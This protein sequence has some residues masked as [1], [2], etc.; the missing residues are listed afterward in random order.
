[1]NLVKSICILFLLF[2][3]VDHSK[4]AGTMKKL[5][6][7]STQFAGLWRVDSYD[8]REFATPP[9][10]LE[11]QLSL[12]AQYS[13]FPLGQVMEFVP[14]GAAILPG[15]IDPVSMKASGP[16]GQTMQLNLRPPYDQKLCTRP[17]WKE[18]CATPDKPFVS[19]LMITDISN[20]TK[21][22]TKEELKTWADIQPLEFKLLHMG[23][24]YNL[25]AWFGKNGDL[26][27]QTIL[28][29]QAKNGVDVG[30][31]AVH[32]KRIGK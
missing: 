16:V 22:A 20:W 15:S 21:D 26:Y 17:F 25:L 9:A 10:D 30:A 2:I 14:N 12:E 8:F 13:G 29:G 24:A 11:Q 5:T 7:P 18:A 27:F 28:H 23:R 31:M 32:L 6:H 1:M 3:S 19:E 4:A